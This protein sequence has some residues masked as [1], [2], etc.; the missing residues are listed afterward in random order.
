MAVGDKLTKPAPYRLLALDGGGMRGV[1]SIEVLA[2]VER[3]LQQA[4][5]RG[6]DFV[7][8]DYFDYIG[9]T[10]TGA[11]IATGL[12]LGMRVDQV[13]RIYHQGGRE[14]F[15]KASLLRRYQYKFRDD[16]LAAFLKQVVGADTTLGSDRLKTLLLLVMRNATTNSPW[17]I[18]NNP[19]ALFN[20]GE[21]PNLYLPLWQ[22][23]LASSAAP[24]YFPPQ[25]I[26]VGGQTFVFVDGGVTVYNNPAFQLF[27]MATVEPYNLNWSA[28]RETMLLVS[29]G[30]GARASSQAHLRASQM[31]LLYNA[32]SIP[33][34]LMSAATHEQD[35]LCRVFGDCLVGG[36]LD[37]EVGDMRGVAGP[38]RTKL[39]TYLR[40]DVELT[41]EGLDALGLP[42]IRP[43]DVQQLDSVDHLHELQQVGE[44]VARAVDPRHYAG[45]V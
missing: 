13:R 19:R 32:S 34:A 25:T 37:Q 41:R 16:R 43:Q 11:L 15:D 22:L 8:A 39:F 28:G 5:G 33:A 18:S 14:M 40:Y 31:N 35:F 4:L 9:G 36:P 20:R 30:T 29:V 17:P 2:A 27:L 10:S 26:D 44:A 45:F 3:M 21:H 1:L 12:C 7:L 38:A 42:H 23:L 6:D 24:T